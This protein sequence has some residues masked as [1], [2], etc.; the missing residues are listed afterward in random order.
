M[1]DMILFIA[2]TTAG[3][4]GGGFGAVALKFGAE[5]RPGFSERQ[6]LA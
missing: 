5:D 2:I 3:A 4:I 6:P 1:K